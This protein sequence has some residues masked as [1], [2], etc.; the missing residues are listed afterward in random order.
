MIMDKIFNNNDF[1]YQNIC[2]IADVVHTLLA[3]FIVQK[4]YSYG[5]NINLQ[6]T[7]AAVAESCSSIHCKFTHQE[8]RK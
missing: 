3:V 8:A 6:K 7:E 4:L 1:F 5:Y 2:R